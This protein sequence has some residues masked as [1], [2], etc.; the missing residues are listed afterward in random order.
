MWTQGW[1]DRIWSILAVPDAPQHIWDLVIIGGG[2]TGA[3]LL[4][5]AQR[6]GLRALLVEARDFASGTSSRSSKLVHGG[7]RYLRN[8]Q[9]RLVLESVQERERLL[10]EGRGL[11]NPLGFLLVNY[12]GDRIPATVFGLGLVA[13]DLLALKWGHR[14][15]D[16]LDIHEL[17][18][19]LSTHNLLGGFRYFD[20]Q[21]DD[22][23]L[24]LRVLEEAVQDGGARHTGGAALNYARVQALLRRSSGQVCGVVLQDLAPGTHGRT[25]EVQ[26]R[27]VI[28]ATGAWAD[29]LRGMLGARQRLRR[30]RGSHL[31]LPFT[32]LPLSRAVSF[33]H[34][35][36]GRPIFTFPWEG[37]CLVGTT[38]VDHAASLEAE[39]AISPEETE[40]LLTAVQWLFP[41]QQLT[42]A[43]I[44]STWAGVRPVI[45]TGKADPS[46]ESRE[47]VL[48]D[49][50]GLLTLTGG[51]LTT[52]RLMAHKALQVA[53]QRLP[54][55]IKMNVQ[56]RVLNEPPAIQELPEQLTPTA[57]LRLAGRYGKAAIPLLAAAG[58]GETETVADTT[59]LWAELR[60][61]ARAG[62]V[63]HLDDLLLRRVRLGLLLPH[64]GQEFLPRIRQVVQAEL[65]WDDLRWRQEADQYLALC[66]RCYD[67]P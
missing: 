59:T 18:P 9:I 6:L 35:R 12:R 24:V 42:L 47:F 1:R 43:D 14:H 22:A 29:E 38:D 15:Y 63:V 51:K 52:F 39:P 67:L 33:L 41:D 10:K 61:A 30:L 31:A 36:D 54:Q 5:E 8:G 2:I 46:R 4:R 58:P 60:W 17:C 3:G 44:R 11:I 19:L 50:D 55:R 64:G 48:W 53:Q 37:V 62:G 25:A 20:A 32:R 57:R 49:E 21:T 45:H 28:N 23:R 7:F 40:Y 27:V 65:G 26:A 34:P 56:E 66:K 13:Y 16:A